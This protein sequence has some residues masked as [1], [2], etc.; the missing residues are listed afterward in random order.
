M[1]TIFID[2]KRE[3]KYQEL[4][5]TD[6]KL[7]QGSFLKKKDI[8]DYKA[9]ESEKPEIPYDTTPKEAETVQMEE[10]KVE[11][12]IQFLEGSYI[13]PSHVIT[14]EV[15]VEEP[16]VEPV[17]VKEPDAPKKKSGLKRIL[18]KIF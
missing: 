17:V 10:V 3:K 9:R 12:P 13:V 5:M 6:E 18:G 2:N 7:R 8:S 1:A 15:K 11:E 4:N 16:K 14:E